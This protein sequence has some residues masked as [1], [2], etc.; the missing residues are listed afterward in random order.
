MATQ[1]IAALKDPAVKNKAKFISKIVDGIPAISNI[2]N[3]TQQQFSET[4]QSG[5]SYQASITK[6]GTKS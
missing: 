5:N 2:N 3:E 6:P 1:V 4:F